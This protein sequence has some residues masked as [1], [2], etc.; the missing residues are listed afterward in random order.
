MLPFR[1]V[2]TDSDDLTFSKL[3]Q[4]TLTD[5]DECAV[6]CAE[7]ELR[8]CNDCET[9]TFGDDNTPMATCTNTEGAYECVCAAGFL[10]NGRTCDD[11]D[12]CQVL[13]GGCGRGMGGSHLI[14]TCTNIVGGEPTC[15][16]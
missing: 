16:R 9:G 8:P 7:G 13:N 2:V 11:I 10:G 4:V 14:W 15:A 3:L 5:A 1:I 12:E 6:A